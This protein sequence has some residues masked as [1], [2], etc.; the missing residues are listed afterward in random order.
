MIA[1]WRR[2]Y[3]ERTPHSNS[4]YMMPA[5]FAAKTSGGKD[6]GFA[7]L[8]NSRGVSHFPPVT[9]SAGQYD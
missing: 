1:N 4:N 2:D 3:N 9:A 7:F 8:E 5:E 6:A